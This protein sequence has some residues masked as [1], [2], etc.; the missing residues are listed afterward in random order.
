LESGLRLNT[1]TYNYLGMVS[2]EMRYSL[3]VK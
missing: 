1:S 2:R 3:L